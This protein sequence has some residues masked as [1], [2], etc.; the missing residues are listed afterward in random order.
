[1]AGC[2]AKCGSLPKGSFEFGLCVFSCTHPPKP[3]AP[4]NTRKPT[5]TSKPIRTLSPTPTRKP[6]PTPP[7]AICCQCP[8]AFPSC[9]ETVF[10]EPCSPVGCAEMVGG[11]CGPDGLC[12]H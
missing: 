10:P 6:T 12:V 7:I 9:F 5:N 8:G 1:V 11:S 4:P 3:T 2:I